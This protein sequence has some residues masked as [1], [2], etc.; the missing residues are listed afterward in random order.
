MSDLVIARLGQTPD[1]PVAWATFVGEALARSGRAANAAGFFDDLRA[2]GEGARIAAILPGEQAAM[3]AFP[4]PPR[5]PAKY[6][7]A[8]RLLLEDELAQ[9]VDA[10]HVATLK[11]DERGKVYAVDLDIMRRWTD[12]FAEHDAPLTLL[13]PDYDCLDGDAERPVLFVENDRS[14]VSFG[15]QGFAAEKDVALSIVED[16]LGRNP[17]LQVAVYGG[18]GGARSV[19]AEHIVP[20]GAADDEA[21]LRAAA[22]AIEDGAAVNLLQGAFRPRRRR[23]VDFSR[24]RR[25]AIAASLFML[26]LLVFAVADG[27]RTKRVADRYASETQRL[28]NEYFPDAANQD[29]R[30]HARA[31][32][33]GGGGAS[34]LGLSS[35]LDRALQ[36]N[37]AV[38]IDRIRFDEARNL[39]AFSI[40]SPS[41][42]DI[43]AF[44]ETLSTYGVSTTET[45]GYRRAGA[46]W[47]GEMTARL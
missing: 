9:P 26:A 40:R 15:D 31:I 13:T 36:G 6:A 29:P 19:D 16:L 21:L 20:C 2:L 43:E 34:F 47:V 33:A 25:P 11:T 30:S 17:E 1:D 32:L 45:G 27:F 38:A 14:I 42:A 35:A 18:P 44:R 8:A 46:Y 22:K 3:R 12:L 28:H 4:S 10:C 5:N 24:W 39:L 7:S 37:E 23:A 41:D